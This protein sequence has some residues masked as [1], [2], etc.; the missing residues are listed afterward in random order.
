MGWTPLVWIGVRSYGIYLWHEP[1]IVLT[2]PAASHGVDLWRA[3]WQVAA[4]V[5]IAALSWRFVE[6]P[7][8]HGALGRMWSQARSARWRPA[9]MPRGVRVALFGTVAAFALTVV[10]L[11]G[12]LPHVGGTGSGLAATQTADIDPQPP[13]AP[14]ATVRRAGAD[15]VLQNKNG[16]PRTSCRAVVHIG[17]STSAG[18]VSAD[19]LPDPGQ[20]MAAQYARVGADAARF[21]IT[22]ATSIVETLPGGTDA[23]VIAQQLV[24]SGYRGCWVIALGTN[25][26]A[27]VAVGSSVSFATRIARM[28]QVIGN[29]PVLWVNVRSLVTTGPYAESNLQGWNA[30]LTAAC[31]TYA[32][33][34]VYDWASAAQPRWFIPDGIHYYSPGYAA[35]A[36]LIADALATAFPATGSAPAGCVVHTPSLSVPVRGVR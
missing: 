10:A 24:R 23:V 11:T 14:A 12:A 22:P 29:E 18:L 9:A 5:A 13:A 1:I 17:D 2:T 32:H 16:T 27:D 34:R 3:A 36:H 8:R 4:T 33:M 19:Y 21:E 28:M 26:A 7:I 15:P 35:R 6:E 25:D 31:P 20:R 30:A